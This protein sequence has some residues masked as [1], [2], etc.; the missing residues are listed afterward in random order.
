MQK[1]LCL[2]GLIEISSVII[3]IDVAHPK[4]GEHRALAEGNVVTGHKKKPASSQSHCQHDQQSGNDPANTTIIESKDRELALVD[5]AF[6][7]RGD[8]VSRYDE[9]NIERCEPAG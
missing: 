4:G 5:V 3:E 2:C 7:L 1:W 8:K 6:Q 9:E